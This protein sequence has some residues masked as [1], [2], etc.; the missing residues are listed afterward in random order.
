MAQISRAWRGL[1]ITKLMDILAGNYP[2]AKAL[3]I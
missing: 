2:A 1:L 3:A